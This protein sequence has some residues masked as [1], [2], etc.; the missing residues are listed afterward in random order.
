MK[1]V[2]T[3]DL[4]IDVTPQNGLLLP[5]LAEV[6]C[7]MMPDLF[8]IAGDVANSLDGV[9]K[10]LAAFTALPCPKVFVPG[11]H[12]L[13]VQSKHAVKRG[14]DSQYLYSTAIR[15]ISSQQGFHYLVDSPL[16]IGGVGIV[17]SIGLYDYSLRDPRLEG[18]FSIGDY[19]RGEFVDQRFITG[20]WNDSRWIRWRKHAEPCDW[21][22][23]D[24]LLLSQEIFENVYAR[25]T[26]DVDKIIPQVQ[27]LLAIF[28]TNPFAAC[29]NRKEVP[30]PFD[31]YEGSARLG[32]LLRAL[33]AKANVYCICGHKHKPLD[34]RVE[35][36]RVMRL[37]VGYLEGFT[38][39]YR[40][41]A[42]ESLGYMI[43]Q[44]T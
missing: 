42:I 36:V 4:H 29:I 11:N 7:E 30:D 39:D 35:N 5:Y 44:A 1:I 22:L 31:A 12:D 34:I 19:V 32:E 38:D 14:Q 41:K 37:P 24:R 26:A 17:G 10:A 13:W 23:R 33:T 43:L 9:E 25:L 6:A 3:S 21:R 8:V 2:F 28:H 27:S 16:V 18:I 20:M 40:Q 15:E